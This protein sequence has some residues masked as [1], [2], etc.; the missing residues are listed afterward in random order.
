MF[1]RSYW[2]QVLGTVVFATLATTMFASGGSGGGGGSTSTSSCNDVSSL[3]VKS[4]QA[5]YGWAMGQADVT[6]TLK[7]CTPDYVPGG[8]LLTLTNLDTGQVNSW[9]VYGL[10]GSTTFYGPYNTNY[11]VD[12]T[13]V[14][15]FTGVTIGSA[16][17]TVTMPSAPLA[18]TT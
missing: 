10:S 15:A 5:K 1:K 7:A 3:S 4:R 11:R 13:I 6:Y 9:T 14:N 18:P 12:L 16:T 2:K 17:A 8:A